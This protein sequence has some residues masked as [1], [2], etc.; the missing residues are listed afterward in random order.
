MKKIIFNIFSLKNKKVIGNRL[1]SSKNTSD[2]EN[3]NV[4]FYIVYLF[5]LLLVRGYSNVWFTINT[6][7]ITLYRFM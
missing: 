1:Y 6:I 3:Y 2:S 4:Y 5:C 7:N